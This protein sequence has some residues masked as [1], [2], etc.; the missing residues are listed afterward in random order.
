MFIIAYRLR[1]IIIS[2]VQFSTAYG[3]LEPCLEPPPDPSDL[4]F[5]SGEDDLAGDLSRDADREYERFERRGEREE[6]L[7]LGE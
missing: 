4:L 5:C 3:L 7:L 1:V 2:R 6:D